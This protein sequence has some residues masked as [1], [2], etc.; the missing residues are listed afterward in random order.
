MK[1]LHLDKLLPKQQIQKNYKGLK[2]T[3]YTVGANSQQ[4]TERRSKSAGKIDRNET[5]IKFKKRAVFF[6]GKCYVNEVKVV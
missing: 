2:I 5:L 1:C 3:A 6:N 4:D